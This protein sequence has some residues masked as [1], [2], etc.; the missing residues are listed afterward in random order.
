MNLK[1]PLFW[2]LKKPNFLSYILIPFTIPIILNNYLLKIRKKIKFS[3]IKS[4]CV[5]NIC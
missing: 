1:K 5:G 3:N 4:I 2:N